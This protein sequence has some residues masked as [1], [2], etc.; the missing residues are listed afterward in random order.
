M[1]GLPWP[2]VAVESCGGTVLRISHRDGTVHET[3]MAYL[4]G[5]SGVFAALTPEIIAAATVVDGDTIGFRMPDG[6]ILDLAPDAL[7]EHVVDGR[8]DGSC[9]WTPEN[10]TVIHEPAR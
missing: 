6:T 5:K 9:G 8:C 1:S 2:I 4:L 10:T 3:D 7:Y